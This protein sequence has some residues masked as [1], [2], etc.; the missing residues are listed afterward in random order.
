MDEDTQTK[1]VPNYSILWNGIDGCIQ[2]ANMR[3]QHLKTLAGTLTQTGILEESLAQGL[4]NYRKRNEFQVNEAFRGRKPTTAQACLTTYGTVFIDNLIKSRIVM[5]H[6]FATLGNKMN[7]F[8]NEQKKLQKKLIGDDSRL[9]KQLQAQEYILLRSRNKYVKACK[10]AER[11][12]DVRDKTSTEKAIGDV[13][14]FQQKAQEA[15]NHAQDTERLHKDVV[16]ETKKV[17]MKHQT[18]KEQ[19]AREFQRVEET[20]IVRMRQAL[21]RVVQIHIE[22]A[23]YMR[24]LL[25]EVEKSV[26]NFDSES[27]LHAF[28][29]ALAPSGIPQNINLAEFQPYVSEKLAKEVCHGFGAPKPEKCQQKRKSMNQ[30]HQPTFNE[31]PEASESMPEKN[32]DFKRGSMVFFRPPSPRHRSLTSVTTAQPPVAVEVGEKDLVKATFDFEPLQENMIGMNTGDII[33]VLN[34]DPCGWWTG[35]KLE[36]GEQGLFPSNYVRALS[37]EYE[38]PPSRAASTLNQQPPVE[39]A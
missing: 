37:S 28:V 32:T 8:R 29:D 24:S 15:I 6:E 33:R 23:E 11:A 18:A 22:Q 1:A 4:A 14:K 25:A 16:E 34:K 17:Q 36:N 3:S 26:E 39:A 35:E 27:D 10:D 38:T 5:A 7:S 21:A 2:Q 9:D 19:L 12:V 30:Q 13:Y 31:R 20:R